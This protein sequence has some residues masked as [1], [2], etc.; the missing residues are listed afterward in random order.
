MSKSVL[1]SEYSDLNKTFLAS[2][3]NEIRNWLLI[4]GKNRCAGRLACS[5]TKFLIGKKKFHYDPSGDIGDYVVIIN[6]D[7]IIMRQGNKIYNVYKPGRPGRSLKEENSNSIT[8]S[9]KFKR[10]VKS[11]LSNHGARKSIKRLYVYNNDKH[12]HDSQNLIAINPK[13]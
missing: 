4:D 8:S 3:K 10:M 9:F 12:P 7:E 2:G 6:A 5:I 11:I 1:V 13:I